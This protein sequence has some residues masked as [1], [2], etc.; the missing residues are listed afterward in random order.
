MY[1]SLVNNAKIHLNEHLDKLK[2]I[3]LASY[4]NFIL[5][6]IGRTKT[7]RIPV[8]VMKT[9]TALISNFKPLLQIN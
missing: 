9:V 6:R 7:A 8:I 1:K 5:Q 3:L 4:I 2:E